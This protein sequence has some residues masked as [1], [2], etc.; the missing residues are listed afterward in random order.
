[1]K[2]SIMLF[3]ARRLGYM[4]NSRSPRFLVFSAHASAGVEFDALPLVS[5]F[6]QVKPC[7]FSNGLGK[8]LREPLMRVP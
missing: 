4:V 1:M 7:L 6:T 3:R 2:A 8:A 5:T